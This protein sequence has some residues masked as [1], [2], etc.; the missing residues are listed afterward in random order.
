M[1]NGI[2]GYESWSLVF[3]HKQERFECALNHRL[4]RPEGCTDDL[5]A[6]HDRQG[7]A[8]VGLNAFRQCKT[9][10]F[11]WQFQGADQVTDR[12]KT[13]VVDFCQREFSI[14]EANL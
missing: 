13:T 11:A 5:I 2:D 7:A 12:L 14:G 1:Q 3:V 8:V 9:V 10:E 6:E 4:R